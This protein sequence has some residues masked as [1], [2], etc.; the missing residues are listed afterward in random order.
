MW[1]STKEYNPERHKVETC[2]TKGNTQLHRT[3]ASIYINGLEFYVQLDLN[4][5]WLR[6]PTRAELASLRKGLQSDRRSFCI[7]NDQLSLSV[8]ILCS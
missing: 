2:C 4:N 6:F 1:E 3:L 7:L 8:K 5:K